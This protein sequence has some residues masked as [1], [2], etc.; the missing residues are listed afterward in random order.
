MLTSPYQL[1]GHIFFFNDK[2]YLECKYFEKV[3]PLVCSLKQYSHSFK[4]I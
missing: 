3:N 1:I 2:S 4:I